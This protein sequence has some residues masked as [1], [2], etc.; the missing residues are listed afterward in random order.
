[1]QWLTKDDWFWAKV[2][3]S[4]SPNTKPYSR[5][6]WQHPIL[7]NKGTFYKKGSF[8]IRGWIC[9]ASWC[10]TSWSPIKAL[11]W[12]YWRFYSAL[13][14][15]C[16]FLH[17]FNIRKGL[18]PFTNSIWNTKTVVW[19]SAWKK[20][21]V[22]IHCYHIDLHSCHV[23]DICHTWDNITPDAWQQSSFAP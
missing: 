6:L 2:R 10:F 23:H 17:V 5:I 14:T 3:D 13:Q 7:T 22:S 11:P 18:Q 12:T 20:H 16:W 9:W 1:M 4:E 8:Y 15:P 19:Q 21:C